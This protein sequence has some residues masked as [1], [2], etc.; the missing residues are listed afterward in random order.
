[1]RRKLYLDYVLYALISCCFVVGYTYIRGESFQWLYLVISFIFGILFMTF[2][3]VR[4]PIFNQYYVQSAYPRNLIIPIK[5]MN[6]ANQRAAPVMSS[7]LTGV[8][9]GVTFYSFGVEQFKVE[10]FVGA[11]T[12][13]VI[14]FYFEPKV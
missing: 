6:R 9:L 8:V 12:S 5:P 7:L 4:L 3:I 2:V 10:C 11:I 1:M 13:G 14:S